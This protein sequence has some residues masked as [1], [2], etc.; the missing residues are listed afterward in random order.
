MYDDGKSI[1]GV[2]TDADVISSSKISRIALLESN[3]VLQDL[4]FGLQSGTTLSSQWNSAAL[5]GNLVDGNRRNQEHSTNTCIRTLNGEYGRIDAAEQSGAKQ[6]EWWRVDLGD[7]YNIVTVIVTGSATKDHTKNIEVVV[8]PSGEHDDAENSICGK[9]SVVHSSEVSC[10]RLGRYVFIRKK[11]LLGLCEVQ[12]M[13]SATGVNEREFRLQECNR[14]HTQKSWVATK[15]M[16]FCPAVVDHCLNMPE[17]WRCAMNIENSLFSC[18]GGVQDTLQFCPTGKVCFHPAG[19]ML[20]AAVSA[21]EAVIAMCKAPNEI[22]AT[23]EPLMS[24]LLSPEFLEG[25]EEA[26][27]KAHV[28]S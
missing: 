1:S 22:I 4:S 26:A 8:G 9:T 18:P 20:S 25:M 6:W 5:S 11:G 23:Q 12:V 24:K 3:A 14:Y 16:S 27:G 28:S 17:V 19:G 15:A 13:G 21:E 2:W 10:N 7:E